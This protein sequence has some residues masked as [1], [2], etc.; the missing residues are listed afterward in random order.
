MSI[1]GLDTYS[2]IVDNL[3]A[4]LNGVTNKNVLYSMQFECVHYGNGQ[5][6]LLAKV[7][8]PL[9]ESN[10]KLGVIGAYL[11]LLVYSKSS[12]ALQFLRR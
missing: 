5:V 2:Y 6:G 1:T 7:E 11:L 8:Q 9:A 4:T 3:P 12:V 10:R